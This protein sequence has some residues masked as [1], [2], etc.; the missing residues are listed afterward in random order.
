VQENIFGGSFGFDSIG[1][2]HKQCVTE[3]GAK[4]T[5]NSE[6]MQYAFDESE[7]ASELEWVDFRCTVKAMP[8]NQTVTTDAC[9]YSIGHNIGLASLG[10]EKHQKVCLD[11]NC[12]YTASPEN[13]N[14]RI[15]ASKDASGHVLMCPCGEKLEKAAHTY[16][17]F[18]ITQKAT[19]TQNGLKA[20][21]CS[22]CKYED[23]QE[24]PMASS[25]K[26]SATKFVCDGK[27]QKPTVTVKDSDGKQLT[28]NTDYTL[29]YSSD[30]STVGKHSVTVTFIGDYA[31]SKACDYT[32]LPGVTTKIATASKSTSIK[33]AWKAVPGATGYRVYRY[34]TAAKKYVTLKNTKATSYTV[35]GL[36]SGTSYKFAVRAYA[37]AGG[38]T[39]W[40]DS[41]KTVT[42]TTC[43]GMTTKIATSSSETSVKIAWKA[44]AG[45]TGYRIYLYNT[46]TKKYETLTNTKA[47]SYT[48]T[49][50]KS[51]TEY[52]FAVRAYANISGKTYWAD[53]YKTV[54]ATTKPGTPT[55][56]ATAGAKKAT[57]KWNA[58]TGAD[59]YV[60]YMATSKNGKYTKIATLKGN[61]K[62]SYTKTGLTAGKTYYFKVAAYKTYAGS[63][64]YGAYSAVKYAKVK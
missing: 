12:S 27:E 20:R 34:D 58:Q 42:T 52:K 11:T 22:V 55:L 60:L 18:T 13:H 53:S 35:S 3:N 21:T 16:G 8:S 4:L 30:G 41:Y 47:T 31:G 2:P 40:A 25:I 7:N 29:T 59:G 61:T 43:P 1:A 63:N 44:V 5:I 33:L 49:K 28:E 46:S 38:K 10:S 39:Y 48:A 26:L 54:A 14:F 6:Y 56:T 51:A 19:N 64:V 50:L 15:V 32:V 9:S 36:E 62:V 37:A 57:L 17:E 23:T 45:A 24:I